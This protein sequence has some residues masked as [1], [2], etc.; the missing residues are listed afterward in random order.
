MKLWIDHYPSMMKWLFSTIHE[1][2]KDLDESKHKVIDN[3]EIF[4]RFV[5]YDRTN[6]ASEPIV[7]SHFDYDI[8]KW[9]KTE[10]ESHLEK[11][12]YPTRYVFKKTKISDL[13]KTEVWNSFGFYR[14]KSSEF[15]AGTNNRFYLYKLRRT[16]EA[17][18]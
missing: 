11:F 10:K 2:C 1:L 13:D 12:K 18:G 4:T 16:V 14:S 3:L 7:E 17:F 15:Q 6:G 9:F 8:L 5:Y